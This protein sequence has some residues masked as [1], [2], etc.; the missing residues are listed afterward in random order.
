MRKQTQ[1]ARVLRRAQAVRAVGAG[2]HI[3]PRLRDLPCGAFCPAD[4]G[5]AL[6]AGRAPGLAGARALRS[7]PH[8]HGRARAAPQAPRHPSASGARL[9]PRAMELART[10]D[11]LRPRDRGPAWPRECP[12]RGK[13]PRAAPPAPPDALIPPPLPSPRPQSHARRSQTRPAGARASC[14]RPMQR[15]CGA[16]P[17][18]APAGGAPHRAPVCPLVP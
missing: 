18:P 10:R 1:E 15:A 3:S 9:A 17:C 8:N 12:R 4:M 13:K 2:P 11:R 5:A 14:A 7:P 16:W 6:C